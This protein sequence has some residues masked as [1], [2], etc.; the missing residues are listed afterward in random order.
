MTGISKNNKINQWAFSQLKGIVKT[1]KLR[2]AIRSIYRKLCFS[3]LQD[4]NHHFVRKIKG[5]IRLVVVALEK[6]V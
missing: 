1:L 2:K 3:N 4:S 6:I 5:L